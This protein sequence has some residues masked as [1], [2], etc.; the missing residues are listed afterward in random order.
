MTEMPIQS[1]DAVK[2]RRDWFPFSKA[3]SALVSSRMRL[4]GIAGFTL[5]KYSVATPLKSARQ[6]REVVALRL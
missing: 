1:T 4:P 2:S 3:I 6:V 5:R